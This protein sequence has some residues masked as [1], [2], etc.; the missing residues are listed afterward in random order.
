MNKTS[1]AKHLLDRASSAELQDWAGRLIDELTFSGEGRGSKSQ[2]LDAIEREVRE[3]GLNARTID[4][5]PI[6]S[7]IDKDRANLLVITGNEDSTSAGALHRVSVVDSAS[8]VAALAGMRLGHEIEAHFKSSSGA[9]N[10]YQFCIDEIAGNAGPTSMTRDVRIAELPVVV[11]QPTSNRPIREFDGMARFDVAIEV[12]DRQRRLLLP[13]MSYLVLEIERECRKIQESPG[14]PARIE[15]LGLG[16]PGSEPEAVG[17][18]ASSILTA[19]G[20]S[21]PERARMRVAE[22]LEKALIEFLGEQEQTAE[23][24]LDDPASHFRIVTESR[25][26]L[27][28]YRLDVFGRHPATS[29]DNAI[30]KMAWLLRNIHWVARDF[31]DIDPCCYLANEREDTQASLVLAGQLACSGLP[32]LSEIESRLRSAAAR[33]MIRFL[34]MEGLPHDLMSPQTSLD[35]ASHAAF[36]SAPDSNVSRSIQEAVTALNLPTGSG[37]GGVTSLPAWIHAREG[38]PVV[39]FG[40]DKL[41]VAEVVAA[42]VVLALAGLLMTGN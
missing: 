2:I 21:N 25:S 6:E 27:A 13:A 3:M 32:E 40:P 19:K 5:I 30:L 20:L 22:H 37:G 34:D 33:G 35:R 10:A 29:A 39:A 15:F 24:A 36:H 17:E 41:D 18:R 28:A 1:T 38:R 7:D 14:S 8:I 12:E 4:R 9:L 42:G 31:S 16:R 23:S 11:M 26:H